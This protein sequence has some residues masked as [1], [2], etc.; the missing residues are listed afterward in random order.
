[1]HTLSDDAVDADHLVEHAGLK[2]ARRHVVLAKVARQTHLQILFERGGDNTTAQRR[3][4]SRLYVCM[5]PF[6]QL[7]W[8]A[9]HSGQDS[10]WKLVGRYRAAYRI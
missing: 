10:T 7:R 4:T 1:M 6:T 9:Q 8:Y 3:S 5:W 2:T